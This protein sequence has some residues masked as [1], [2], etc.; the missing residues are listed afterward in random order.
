MKKPKIK[1]LINLDKTKK[2]IKTR[3]NQ[4]TKKPGATINGFFANYAYNTFSLFVLVYNEY[5]CVNCQN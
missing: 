2:L 1:P 3:K 5:Y 4:Y